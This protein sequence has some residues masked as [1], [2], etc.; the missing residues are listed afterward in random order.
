MLTHNP[1]SEVDFLL[2][3]IPLLQVASIFARLAFVENRYTPLQS[4]VKIK[5]KVERR[6]TFIAY[7][8]SA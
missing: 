1:L 4:Q 3:K 5:V 6:F 2:N 7:S 8:T